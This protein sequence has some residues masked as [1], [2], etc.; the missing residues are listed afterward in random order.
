MLWLCNIYHSYGCCF[1]QE[2]NKQSADS[3]P[4]SLTKIYFL[5]LFQS[6]NSFLPDTATNSQLQNQ[7]LLSFSHFF[8][9][10]LY[11]YLLPPLVPP[12]GH[13]LVWPYGKSTSGLVV[14]M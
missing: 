14:T 10:F 4:I 9:N 8:S 12:R 11:F 13:S 5:W 3:R 6:F 1:D 7:R 2:R